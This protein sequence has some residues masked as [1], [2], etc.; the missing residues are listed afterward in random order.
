MAPS[1]DLVL[2]GVNARLKDGFLGLA[3]SVLVHAAGGPILFDVG[4]Q[5]NR[6]ALLKNLAGL[7]MSPD[8]VTR[9]FLS[10]LHYDHS[11]NIDLFSKAKIYVSRAEHDYAAAPHPEDGF[12]PWGIRE[13]LARQDLELLDGDGELDEGVGYIATPGHT[14]GCHSMVLRTADKGTVVLAGDAIK[15]PNEALRGC[16]D[17]AFDTEE[18]GTRSIKRILE[19]ADRIIP[20]HAPELVRQGEAFVWNESAE[21]PLVI[22]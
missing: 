12:I 11:L 21:L 8:D 3:S 19:V 10:H 16:C 5:G 20:G 1:Y 2:R 9:V 7:D 14:P 15:G 4:F 13:Q 22:R 17:M 6:A 18:A